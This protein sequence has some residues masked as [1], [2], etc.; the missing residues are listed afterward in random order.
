MN[1]HFRQNDPEYSHTW[2][3]ETRYRFDERLAIL[4]D[5]YRVQPD[6]AMDQIARRYARLDHAAEVAHKAS[7]V[8][9]NIAL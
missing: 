3:V 4:T 9:T 8:K 1:A 7:Q 5:G 6:V 2:S